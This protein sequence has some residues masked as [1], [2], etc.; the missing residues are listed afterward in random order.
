VAGAFAGPLIAGTAVAQTIGR[1]IVDYHVVG[2]LPLMGGLTGG[3]TALLLAYAMR[4]PVSAS[5]ALVSATIGS[6]WVTAQLHDVIW[7]GVEKVAFSLLGSIVVGFVV[8]AA[9][10]SVAVLALAKV[11]F[12]TGRKLMRL[13][14]VSVS[15]QA[16]GYGSNDA[17]KMM[18]LI[19]AATMINS[20]SSTFIVPLWAIA[21]SVLAFAAGTALGGLRVAK[22][23]GGKLF[24]IRPLHALSFQVAA[25]ATV[26]TA[27]ALGGPLSTTESTASA[28][29]GVGAA[30]NPHALRWQVARELVAAWLLTAPIGALCGTLATLLLRT[31]VHGAR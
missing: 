23:V 1:G 3:L 15:L 7:S 20:T 21:V 26:L 22:T 10:Y 6:L 18:G 29:M 30:A 16:I 17:E 28:I 19:V 5:V 14:Y 13:Q 9:I 31:L 27:S 4:V 25:A 12:S 11:R 24:R 8:G 2:S